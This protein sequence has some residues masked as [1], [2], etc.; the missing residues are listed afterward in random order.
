MI[1]RGSAWNQR[2]KNLG[3]HAIFSFVALQLVHH[4]AD[5]LIGRE[6]AT[7]HYFDELSL[8]NAAY[9]VF[10]AAMPTPSIELQCTQTEKSAQRGRV[11]LVR[12]E[13]RPGSNLEDFAT[14]FA[15]RRRR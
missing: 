2:I 4:L 14:S 6:S 5:N 15:R 10:R 9:P 12:P 13:D 3:T 8:G 7:S 1:L 11:K